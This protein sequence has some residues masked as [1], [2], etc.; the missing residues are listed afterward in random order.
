MMRD[1]VRFYREAP[2][3][4]GDLPGV[5]LGEYLR[6]RGYGDAF[7]DDHLYPMAAAV[8]STPAAEIADY[9][10]AAFIR[11][12]DIMAA[13][14][15]RQAD[16]E[17]VDGGSRAYVERLSLGIA[18]RIRL[19]QLV[20]SVRRSGGGVEVM[21]AD[22]EPRRFDHVVIATHADQALAML[23][24][25]DPEE[26]RLLGAFGYT[27]NRTVLHSD[28][29]MMPKR[30]S[31]WSS[32]NYLASTRGGSRPPSVT[33]WMNR[34]QGIPDATPRFV[35]L[36]PAREPANILW[37]GEYRHPCF[38]AA[39]LAAQQAL[40]S[41]QG[42]RNTWFCGS[43]FGAGF[44]E[45]GLQAGLAVAEALG[46]VRRPW[47]VAGESGRIVVTPLVRGGWAHAS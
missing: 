42:L 46:G 27:L 8:W 21:A 7:R 37:S 17:N 12:C 33:Y 34:L 26:G 2:R 1:L 28:R 40:W 31:V 36:N 38:S 18:D 30:L 4:I 45:D 24:D 14:A 29:R 47:T 6:V 39:A 35:S 43:Y 20:R 22:G 11:F 19:S 13:D 10:A 44:H 23:A 9:P 25:P 16:V 15:E 5:T 3:D 41:L 32:W